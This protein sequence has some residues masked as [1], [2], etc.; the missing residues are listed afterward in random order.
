ML[1]ELAT[2]SLKYGAWSDNGRVEATWAVANGVL[3]FEWHEHDGPHVAPPVREGLGS[4]L[5]KRG[6][7]TAKVE[8]DFMP[9][10]LQ[11]RIELPL[12]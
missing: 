3:K 11:C 2:N 4:A 5:I 7:P 9:E 8:H 12:S 1:H 6:M 10:G